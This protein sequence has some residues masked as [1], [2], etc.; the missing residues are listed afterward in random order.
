MATKELLEEFGYRVIAAVDGEDAVT[1]FM[2]NKDAVQLLLLDVIMP[3]MNGKEA[4]E[5]IKSIRTDIRT[6]FMSGYSADILQNRFLFEEGLHYIAKP[7]S[8]VVLLK[9]IREVLDA[10]VRLEKG[11]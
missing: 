8:P 5:K 6:I 10:E 9:T 1:L 4:Y 2:Q 11:S 3:K 7:V